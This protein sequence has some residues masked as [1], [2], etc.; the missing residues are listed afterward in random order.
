MQK[1][2]NTLCTCLYVEELEYRDSVVCQQIV[3]GTQDISWLGE[4][5]VFNTVI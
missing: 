3:A 4:C 1:G 2:S 5:A